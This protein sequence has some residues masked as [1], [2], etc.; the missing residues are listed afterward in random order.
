VSKEKDSTEIV[1]KKDNA[2]VAQGSEWAAMKEQAQMMIR[3]KF[4]PR[5]L[6]TA[7]KVIAVML[8]GREL[9]IPPM[10]AIR[11][12]HVIDAK[13]TLS[14]E[15]MMALAYQRVPG[16]V[17]T[18]T[19]EQ[20]STGAVMG[21]V[22]AGSRPG[23]KPTIIAYRKTDALAAGLLQKQTWKSYGP[24][25]YRA[26][27]I[28]A[29]VRVVAPDAILGCYTPEE[30]ETLTP[31]KSVTVEATVIETRADDHG[32]IPP[33]IQPTEPPKGKPDDPIS[34]KDRRR[35][36]AKWKE[37]AEEIKLPAAETEKRLKALI[38]RYGY[39]STTKICQGDL[40]TILEAIESY[41]VPDAA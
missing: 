25:M 14:A 28:S 38:L 1:P 22:V 6:D 26:R 40:T 13:P 32:E 24:A 23:A 16:L 5:A 27:A 30:I 8:A 15:T 11:S 3:S 33:D 37:R 29:W 12:I 7:E 18:V 9:G 41:E 19:M 21:C 20:D 10:Q 34:E 36:F 17:C 39:D 31:D 4:V 2:L 35:I